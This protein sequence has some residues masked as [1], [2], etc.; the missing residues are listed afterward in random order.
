MKFHSIPIMPQGFT[1]MSTNCGLKADGSADLALFVSE[2]LCNAA[3]VFTRN[4]CPGAPVIVGRALIK[5]GRLRAIVVNSKISN[6]GTGDPGVADARLM[7]ALAAAELDIA[8]DEVLMSSTGV[9]LKRLPM[10]KLAS[11]IAG[12][13]AQLSSDPLVGACGIMTTDTVP[14]AISVNIGD[15]VLTIVGKGSGMISPNMATMLVYA[16]TDAEIASETLDSALREAVAESFNMLSIDTDTS[17]SDTVAI[18]ANGLAGPVPIDNFRA[19]LSAAC[20]R[21]TEM[22]ARDGE[23][24]S[25]LLRTTAKSANSANDARFVAR[26]LVDSPL[27]KTMVFGGDPNIGRVLMAVGKCVDC[28]VDLDALRVIVNGHELY[29]ERTRQEFDEDQ[30][31]AELSRDTVDIVVH[32]NHGTHEATAYGCDLTH[33]YIDE[34]AAYY[35]S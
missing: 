1:C 34:N 25:K 5:A 24:A 30:I 23:G 28:E 22:L 15:A 14:K 10:D 12:A 26:A 32:L 29:R 31:R 33:G 17:T 8:A 7:G 19:G 11:G 20:I 2:K 21:M 3:A 4:L 18:L 27:I 9:I 16:F 35:S 6:V 13:S